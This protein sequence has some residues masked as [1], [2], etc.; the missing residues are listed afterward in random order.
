MRCKMVE[1]L[2]DNVIDSILSGIQEKLLGAKKNHEWKKLFVE[3]G[4]FFSEHLGDNDKFAD[5]LLV[6]FSD[7]NM[8]KMAEELK[9]KNGFQIRRELHDKMYKLMLGYE[10]EPS[11]A[12]I[13]ISHFMQVIITYLEENMQVEYRELFLNNWRNEEEEELKRIQHQIEKLTDIVKKI[14]ENSNKVFSINDIETKIRKSTISPQIGLDFFEID[15][16]QFISIFRQRIEQE[17]LYIVGKSREETI[18]C[19]LNEI[20][21]MNLERITLVVT[22]EEE[23]L[24]L[25]ECNISGNILIPFFFAENI[26][27]I[28]GNTNIFIYGEDEP[29]SSREKIILRKRTKQNLV[30]ALE[31]AGM[32]TSVAHELVEDTH[33]LYIPM[34]KRIY[35]GAIHKMSSWEKL[36]PE[37]L[38][39]VLLCGKWKHY[40]G[41]KI[42][43]E[44]LSGMEYSHIMREL[45][46]Y[47]RGENP[48]IVELECHHGKNVQLACVEDAWEEIGA[49][50]S[51]E[52]WRKFIGLL[53]EVLIES[54]PIFEYPFEKHFEASIYASKP[55]WSPELKHGMIRSLI[56]RAYYHKDEEKQYQVNTVVKRILDT[57]DT[58]ERWGYIAQYFPDLC[59]AAPEV[60]LKRVEAELEHPTGM[61]ELFEAQTGDII[62]GRHYYIHILWA[63][64][65]LLLQKKYVVRTVKWLWKVD[66]LNIK[67][68]ISNS[69]KSI[70]ENIFCAWINM[71]VLSV[72]QKKE[73]A[74][75]AMEHY[76][77]AWEIL[78][79]ELPGKRT[80]VCSSLNEPKYRVVDES[81]E[82]YMG[83]VNSIYVEYIKLCAETAGQSVDKWGKIISTV[84]TY[85]DELI[86]EVFEIMLTNIEY[87]DDEGKI[88]I[89]NKLRSEIYRHRYFSSAEWAMQENKICKFEKAMSQITTIE[90]EYEYLYLFNST[91]DF[92]LLNPIPYDRENLEV[93]AREKN[94]ELEEV[95]IENGIK[96]FKEK[97]LS[98]KKILELCLNC[99]RTTIGKYIA[100]YYDN[101]QFRKQT[102]EM[103]TDIDFNGE[104]IFD[105]VQYFVRNGKKVIKEAVEIVRKKGNQNLL[106]NLLSLETITDGETALISAESDEIK[107]EFWSVN[108]K[109]L[110]LDDEKVFQWAISECRKYGTINSY[111]ELLFNAKENLSGEEIYQALILINQVKRE[112]PNVMVDYYLEEILKLLQ[113]LYLEDEEKCEHIAGVEWLFRN[114][115][116]WHQMKFVQKEMKKDPELYAM[117][118]NLIYLK[119]GKTQEDSSE[120]KKKA[121]EAVFDFF[122]KAHF[123]PAE[124]NGRV[125]YEDLEKWVERFKELLVEQ[126]Q[127]N[128]FG[129]L[130]GRLFAYS[131]VG[132]DGYMP[133][134]A[135]RKLIEDIY[136]EALK[137]AYIVAE[138]NKRGVYTPNAGRKEL[139]LAEQYE[140]NADAIRDNYPHVAEIY[141]NLSRDY[142]VQADIERKSAEDEW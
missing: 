12:E 27:A 53:Y 98:L 114:V 89:K 39:A 96:D 90:L 23:W 11:T 65:Q 47:M 64:E 105:Y 119:E 133:C 17:R 88:F 116:E 124:I 28:S 14:G 85:Y 101:N 102:L 31:K 63:V 33:G 60:I 139:E 108:L 67:Y 2:T 129:H 77:N 49:Y 42:V 86:D 58:K 94:V 74:K 5:D 132:E 127:V 44:E 70:L 50:I 141:D 40:E 29:C 110:L 68:S 120:E 82:L 20:R 122:H 107:R 106:V 135:V 35:N 61:K 128:L 32:D 104:I 136:D 79:S 10:I 117:L 115:L 93:K 1:K 54:E 118:V 3:T 46:P 97:G 121:T 134:E 84:H 45:L 22:S 57:I 43:L 126:N 92:P 41:D 76:E 15:D 111:L 75:W 52:I 62:R 137:N 36:E 21:K 55:D 87:M 7:D 30:R 9:G 4:N 100:Q 8:K 72:N 83:D 109:C 26:T 6:I 99:E 91:Y 81:D 138:E 18:F 95:E 73:L 13:Y 131:P 38:V 51:E 103:I 123:C 80:V 25:A 24:H 71:S 69:P 66:A 112:A 59:E 140:K 56:M 34:K 125:N 78:C 37:L 16:D 19:I 48:L 113:E 142:K 130:I